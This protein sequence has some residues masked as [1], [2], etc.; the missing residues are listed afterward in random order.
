[1]FGQAVKHT[2]V[3]SENI[4]IPILYY[5]INWIDSSLQ[6]RNGL[7]EVN[8]NVNFLHTIYWQDVHICVC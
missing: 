2:Q 1:M 6:G 4:Q 7:E 3:K 8:S 5:P